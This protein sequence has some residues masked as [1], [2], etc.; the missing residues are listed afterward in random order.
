MDQSKIE[1]LKQATALVFEGKQVVKSYASD[2]KD[3][4][5]IYEISDIQS[6]NITEH[7]GEYKLSPVL[8]II[9][10]LGECRAKFNTST[11]WDGDGKFLYFNI[12]VDDITPHW[13]ANKYKGKFELFK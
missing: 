2:T 13:D 5:F 6:L 11:V 10:L 1:F 7:F 3:P 4:V 9:N 12:Q 8:E